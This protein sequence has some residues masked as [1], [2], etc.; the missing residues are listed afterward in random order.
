MHSLEGNLTA[1]T[2]YVRKKNKGLKGVVYIS[3]K[4]KQGLKKKKKK[5]AMKPKKL[6]ERQQ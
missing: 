4:K 5:A 1:L 6:K 2:I 3:P